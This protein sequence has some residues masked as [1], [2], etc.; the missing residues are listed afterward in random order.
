MPEQHV[1]IF[2]GLGLPD[3]AITAIEALTPEQMKAWKPEDP[4]SL[5]VFDPNKYTADVQTVMKNTLSNDPTFLSS[6]PEDKINK[7]TLKKYES[8]QYARFQNELVEVATKTLGLEDKELTLEDRKSIKKLTEKIAVTYLAKKG[9]AQGLVEMQAKLSEALASAEAMK[10]EHTKNLTTELEKV[11]GSNTAKLIKTLARVELSSL[12]DI[13]L[14]VAAS[15]ITDP[16]L[17]ELNTLYT[18]VLDANDNLDI[19]QKAHPTLDV[20]DTGGKKLPISAAIRKI[21]LD[22]K[23]G[24]EKKE[25]DDK[26]NPKKKIIIGGG[27]D[28]GGEDVK[29]IPSYIADKINANA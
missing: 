8:G 21:V 11:N 16:V 5:K 20:L 26:T 12:D 28:G 19:K 25:G 10:E 6:I 4:E 22:K 13:N 23:L 1:A 9:G 7:D 17:S 3:E 29:E 24:S 18:V 27:E 14:S 15:Y 2:K